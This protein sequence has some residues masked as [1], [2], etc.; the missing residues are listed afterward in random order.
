MIRPLLAALS[1]AALPAAARAQS[2]AITGGTVYPVSGPK[3]ERGTVVI[4]GGR[5]SAVGGPDLQVPAGVTRLDATGKWI[6]PGLIHAGSTLGTHLF[7]IGA[8]EETQED[9]AEGQIKAA[10]NVAEGIDP[11]S[12]TIPVA[13]AEGITTALT[14]PR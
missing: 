4:T 12:I 14:A 13:R 11:S 9:I 1:L 6:T 5:V 10:F 3:I 2:L 8:Q 7:D